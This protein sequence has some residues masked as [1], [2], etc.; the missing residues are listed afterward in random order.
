[1][2]K[3]I[4]CIAL[5]L[6]IACNKENHNYLF[7]KKINMASIP[8]ELNVIREMNEIH[9]GCARVITI[10]KDQNV[11]RTVNLWAKNLNFKN[12]D[13]FT[14]SGKTYIKYFLDEPVKID[15]QLVKNDNDYV[16]SFSNNSY[17]PNPCIM[18]QEEGGCD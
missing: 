5:F 16:L 11:E 3:I 6:L 1:M 10:S 9:N 18:Y 17:N 15:M 4:V 2:K 8:K 7:Y 14:S 12:K 13:V